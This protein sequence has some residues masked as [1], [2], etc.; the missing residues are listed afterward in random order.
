M[1]MK[2]W[3]DY[4]AGVQKEANKAYE[5]KVQPW[6]DANSCKLV[7][8]IGDYVVLSLEDSKYQIVSADKLPGDVQEALDAFVPGTDGPLGSFM[9]SADVDRLR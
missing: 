4:L 8:G 6:L 2:L 9:P 7:T 5:E 3:S 1:I